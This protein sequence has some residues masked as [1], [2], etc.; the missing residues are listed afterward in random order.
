MLNINDNQVLV[1]FGKRLRKL[2]KLHGDLSLEQLSGYSTLDHTY[3]S[4]IERGLKAPSLITLVK[5]AKGLGLE[6]FT[7]LFKEFDEEVYPQIE[8]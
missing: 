5:Y 2:R 7:D 1:E 8:L 6:K 4:E 3:L